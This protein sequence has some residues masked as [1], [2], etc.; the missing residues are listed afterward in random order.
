MNPGPLTSGIFR[1]VILL[2]PDAGAWPLAQRRLVLAHEMAHAK[3][4]D[5]LGQLLCQLACAVYW[6]N[7]LVWYAVR[8]LRVARERTCDDFGLGLGESAPDY[9]DS[10]L[11]KSHVD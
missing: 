6:F 8:Q 3:R 1:Q 5:G 11:L 10:L 2:R 4:R 7:P 9:A